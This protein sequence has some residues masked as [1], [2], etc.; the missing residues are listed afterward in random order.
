MPVRAE[1]LLHT[2]RSA[3]MVRR[4]ASLVLL[5]LAFPTAGWGQGGPAAQQPPVVRAATLTTS[6]RIDGIPDE[7]AWRAALPATSFTQNDP[8]EGRPAS[9]PT[10]VR[11]LFDGENLYV[12]ALLHD[13]SGV[14]TRLA[15]RDTYL[16]DTDWFS[17]ALDSYHDHLTAYR[18]M[19][20]PS[21]VRSDEVLSGGDFDG[22]DESW[23]PVWEVETALTD[24]G[25]SVE[26]RIPFSQ[27]R[28]AAAGDTWGIQLERSIGRRQEEAVFAFTPK[29]ERGGIAR[30]G[31]L[32]GLE[33]LE[34][35][36]GLELLPYVVARAEY[37]P[38]ERPVE[39]SFADPY[40]DGSAYLASGG[41][42]FKY[43]MASNLTLDATVNPDFG[44]VELDPAVVNLTAYETRFEEKRPFFVEG[45]DIF[46]FGDA[47][48]WE[49]STQLL[50]SR[51]IG[52]APRGVTSSDALYV[53]APTTATILG[54][55]KVTGR[56]DGGWS[57]GF[58]EAVTARETA[59]YT[60]AERTVGREVV[61][62]LTN[63]FVGRIRRTVAEGRTVAGGMATMVQRR[64]G[65]LTL[66]ESMRAD[67]YSAGA[68]F[69]HEW[70]DRTWAVS[71]YAAASHIGGSPAA[72][73]AAQRSS[74]RY[75][76]RPDAS[77]LSLD[78]DATSLDGYVVS[79]A[80]EKQAGL[81]WRGSAEFSAMSPGF[82]VNDLGYQRDADRLSAG[83]SVTYVENRPGDVFR[84]WNVDTRAD[85]SWNY[86]GD[87]LGVW[88]ETEVSG[89][90]SSYWTGEIGFSHDF[91]GYDD[92]LTRGGPLT[93]SLS[94]SEASFRVESD[95]RNPWTFE[96]DL[97]YG[98]DEA[99]GETYEV[100]L[101]LGVRSSSSWNL[102]LGPEVNGER[103]PAQYVGAVSDPIAA[104]T[105]GRRYLFSALDQTTVA[106]EARL[107]W[108][109]RPGL[110][111]EGYVQ[112][113]L[114]SAAFDGVRELRAPGTFSFL[115]YGQ[116]AGTVTRDGRELVIDPDGPG[117]AP[118]FR[119]E[120]EDFNERS[121]RG[122]VVLRWEW[123]PGS[124]LFLVWQQQRSDVAELAG[125]RLRRDLNALFRARP[126][127]VFVIKASYW[128]SP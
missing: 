64:L 124:T 125:L 92:R 93:R 79:A 31:H 82:E 42:D 110:T 63:Y 76:Q 88:M 13:S 78:P 54:A 55:G 45:A 123:R 33:G 26:M 120:D 35:G 36:R 103:S 101:G 112:P 7:E 32:E 30:Y 40:R 39:A 86:G 37:I 96:A 75:F 108:T 91:P 100:G 2:E 17:V 11:I 22:G 44:Q 15:R 87:F 52:G 67:A 97:S 113:F 61:S 5:L 9:Q 3:S 107:N 68:D 50:Y 99:G 111:L 85:G 98:W 20:N 24:S 89:Q 25:W 6:V 109:F 43:R 57:V 18:F 34:K 8:E 83:G 71:G 1:D 66:A 106:L 81:H 46:Q 10:E 126:A 127:N 12:A 73:T 94:A 119:L 49:G 56:T 121:L 84:E 59:R 58:L 47:G 28:F 4:P 14:S 116:D 74:A 128:L 29:A 41:L 70:S 23:D 51:R 104:S 80:L 62:P 72:V 105:Y 95:D 77:H 118:A 114:A 90:L 27:L 102:T 122:S 21:G 60:D 69:R 117:P 115:R 65:G 16:P 53:D 38:V 48:G 19:V